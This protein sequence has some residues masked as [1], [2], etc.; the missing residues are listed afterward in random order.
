MGY[1]RNVTLPRQYTGCKIMWLVD[2]ERF[3]RMA[4]LYFK[5]GQLVT[6]AAHNTRAATGM[7]DG[8]CALP[9]GK[10]PL[11]NT[12]RQIKDTGCGGFSSEPFYHLHP[13]TGPRS[14]RA[15]PKA[16]ICQQEPR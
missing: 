16:A 9:E 11:P 10:S 8:A 6:A 1:P 13:Q 15:E 2:G 4:T 3:S 5:G 14:C 7:L 12:G